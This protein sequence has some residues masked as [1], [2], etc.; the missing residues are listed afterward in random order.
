MPPARSSAGNASARFAAW[1]AR[2]RRVASAT[3]PMRESLRGREQFTDT[4]GV[5]HELAS[6]SADEA[7]LVLA[8]LERYAG[9]LHRG[10]LAEYLPGAP[11]EP[12][13]PCEPHRR[14]AGM[15]AQQWL[16]CTPLVAALRERASR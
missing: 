3:R 14:L 8:F 15:T 12:S 7:A 1:L 6:M 13:A 2:E 4:Q 16:A 10:E 11:G 5:R 9:T